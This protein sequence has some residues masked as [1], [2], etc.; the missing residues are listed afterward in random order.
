MPPNGN[1][2][3]PAIEG[4]APVR[5]EP[6]PYA[7]QWITDEDVREVTNV[8]RSSWITSG[9][10]VQRFENEFAALTGAA[11][12]VAVYSCTHA[13]HLCFAALDLEPGDEVITTP[14]TFVATAFAVTHNGARAV[15]ADVR[16]DDFNLDPARVAEKLTPRT[17]ALL[18]MHYGGA[19]CE[20]DE[21]MRIAAENRLFVVEDAAHA[22]G[23][24]Y[25]GRRIGTLGDLTCFSFHAVKNVTSGEGGMITTDDEPLRRRLVSLRFFGIP[26]DAWARAGSERPWHYE[27]REHG[28]KCNMM[29][30]QAALGLS[31][32]KR[33]DDFLRRRREI[34]AL[35]DAA[36]AADETLIPP[37]APAHSESARHL[38]VVRIRPETL[39][40]D[41]D[42]VLRALRAENVAANVHYLPLHLH[43]WFRETFGF[44]R[45]DFPVAEKLYDTIVTLPL[46][47]RMTD[48]DAR[49]VVEALLRIVGYYRR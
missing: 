49:S 13:L 21:L 26:A 12:A 36:F 14:L 47:P 34:C 4:G 18:P 2:G 10:V 25:K 42:R 44:K 11:H 46:F 9:P 35:Y 20:M 31:Q 7:T 17:R 6:L 24:S 33:L 8:L 30:I 40:V 3:V 41:R 48:D 37:R 22:L 29:D 32:L 43:P 38:Y 16:E 39:K 1:T 23:A 5:S 19:P 28:F 27:V 45:G 15:F